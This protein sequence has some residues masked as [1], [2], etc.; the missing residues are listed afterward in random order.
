MNEQFIELDRRFRDVTELGDPEEA[1][2]RS[3]L[4][5]IPGLEPDLGWNE[6]LKSRLVVILGEAGSGKTWELRNQVRV[7]R[8]QGAY[9]FFVRLEWLVDSELIKTLDT[10]D[11]RSFLEW[12]RSDSQA[13]FF[14]D[15]VDEAKVRKPQ[16]FDRALNNFVRGVLL[17]RIHRTRLVVSSRISEWRVHADRDILLQRMGGTIQDKEAKA[18]SAIDK[19]PEFRI[20]QLEPLDRSRVIKFAEKSELRNPESFIEALDVH[21][22]WEFARRPIDVAALIAYWHEHNRLGTLTELIEFDLANKLKETPERIQSDL[23]T[24]EKAREGAECLGAAVIFCRRFSF[25][26]PDIIP[27]EDTSGA[28]IVSDCLP[29]D[30][31]SLMYRAMLSRSV[32]DAAS[33]GRIRFHHRRVAEYLASCWLKRRMEEGC[34]Y[35]VLEDLLFARHDGRWII[36]PSLRAVTAWLAVGNEF[37]NRRIR[38]RVLSW[39]PDL[40][41]SYGDP[42]SL[43]PE[44]KR[45]LLQTLVELYSGRK[46]LYVQVNDEALSRLADFSLA[47]DISTNV[48]DPNIP[49]DIRIILLQLIRHGR[50]HNCLDS[51]LRIVASPHESEELKSYAVA[52][53]RDIGNQRVRLELAKIVRGFET[54]DD[55]LCALLCE[56]LFPEAIGP[57]GL[58]G[59]LEKA[60]EVDR[61]SVGLRWILKRR[62]E[63]KLPDGQAADV[64][65]ELLGLAQK[66]PRVHHNGKKTPISA[67][68]SWLGEVI[69]TVLIK[70]LKRPSLKDNEEKLAARALWL[71]GY[72]R[73]FSKLDKEFPGELNT[74]LDRHPAVRRAYVWLNI[75]EEL[76]IKPDKE[77]RVFSIFDYYEVIKPREGDIDWLIRDI[78]ECQSQAMRIVALKL[79]IDL[80]HSF[81]RKRSIRK[82]IKR[83]IKGSPE[84]KHVYE[85]ESSYSKIRAFL[86]RHGFHDWRHTIWRL[87]HWILNRYSA[88]SDQIWLWRNLEKL[89]NGTAI[90]VLYRLTLEADE[91]RHYRGVCSVGPLRAKRGT[92]ITNA[93]IV[94]WKATWRQF[95]PLLPHEK[96]DPKT[97]DIRVHIGLSGINISLM[98]GDLDFTRMTPDEA[99]LACRYAVNELN[100][101]SSWF[102]ELAKYYPDIVREVLAQCIRGEWRISADREHAHEVLTSLC[103]GGQNLAPLVGGV[104]LKELQ[105][106][107]PLNYQVLEAALCILLKL[108]EPPLTTLANLAAKQIDTKTA[109]DP[110][111]VLWMVVWLQ[112]EATAAMKKL[113]DIVTRTIDPYDL[114]V[115]LCASLST[116]HHRR[117]LLMKKPDYLNPGRLRDLIPLVYRYVRV[118]DDIDRTHAGSYTPTARDHAQDFRNGLIDRLAQI[119][120]SEADD[121]LRA[122]AGD[123]KFARY[124]DYILH[125]LE[126]RTELVAEKTP[127]QPADIR[128]FTQRYETAPRSDYDLF[129]IAQERFIAIKDEVERGEISPRDIFRPDDPESRL[130]K[131]LARQLRD[132]SKGWY[133]VPQEEEIDLE[134][135]P[136]LRIESPG[137]RPV[138]IE[139]KWADNWS[140]RELRQGLI[141]QLVGKYLC[142]PDSSYGIYV[143]G[144]K[145]IKNYWVDSKNKRRFSFDQLI[146]HLEEIA[147]ELVR[148][149]ND[150]NALS[151]YGINFGRPPSS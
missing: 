19:P 145:K 116:R 33:Y 10:A 136:D 144:Y 39:S 128:D 57:E 64:L 31:S 54:I 115:R 103:Y 133:N 7:L 113:K 52:A 92:R 123:R 24:P 89:R 11:E 135:K 76:R 96:S 81:G 139:V 62:L 125:L 94:G 9:S 105:V 56:A 88:L 85:K 137:M 126:Q 119:P 49:R 60:K 25:I 107:D 110:R 84:L 87:R 58:A 22:A 146:Q 127:W 18:A 51:A 93:A 5:I 48:L 4:G 2:L 66:T 32:F 59:L 42:E 15:S 118:E 130:R 109:T 101:F 82:Q 150:I 70:L 79:T 34:P 78:R 43:S 74:L 95:E 117:D 142:A 16:D 68:F 149:R 80:W 91:D 21:H 134:Q 55:N 71:L 23:L 132:R 8:R 98:D 148:Q 41:L 147:E 36:R 46:R 151:V 102:P 131:F 106:R 13:T 138:S 53:I 114:M 67:K 120:G 141:D 75:E 38:E 124:R 17:A 73:R 65:Q 97:I 35:P 63:T 12:I 99:R 122:F 143:L 30:W 72:F 69:A 61:Y 121:V 112:I 3:Y 1:A 28:M 108:Q 111:F 47:P 77:P 50:L 129:K 6:V 90:G 14:L 104:I 40:F 83:A 29:S 26:V 44:Y 86:Y 140:I 45:S 20:V 27:P 37:W 100:G